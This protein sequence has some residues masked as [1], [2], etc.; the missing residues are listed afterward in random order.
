MYYRLLIPDLLG[1]YEKA[2]YLDCDL[3]IEGD[4]GELWKQ[5]VRGFLL[6]AVRN[7]LS[8]TMTKYVTDILKLDAAD[9]FNSGVLLTRRLLLFT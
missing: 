4:V 5:D 7:Y 6:G 2:L 3:L 8:W 9:Y 1:H